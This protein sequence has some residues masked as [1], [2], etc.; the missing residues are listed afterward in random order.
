MVLPEI[1]RT[2]VV[3]GLVLAVL[4][5]IATWFNSKASSPIP[6]NFIW[7]AAFV[8]WLLWVFFG[9]SVSFA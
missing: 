4:A 2:A 7:L 1:L 9:G 5:W 8:V 6:N 3:A